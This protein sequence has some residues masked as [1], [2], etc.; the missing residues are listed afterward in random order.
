MNR[1]R[2]L[3]V[4]AILEAGVGLG[5]LIAPEK[6]VALLFGLE[7]VAAE[8]ILFARIA[9]A[10]VIALGL[11]CWLSR[12]DSQSQ[13]A[14]GLIVGMLFYNSAVLLLLIAAWFVLSLASVGLWLAVGLHAVML[15]WN[16][17]CL[18]H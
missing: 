10:A 9:A 15:V 13:A 12:R 18:R 1:S 7:R 6:P 14:H 17:M 3:H 2:F 5:L 11:A 16:I 8:T 4:T